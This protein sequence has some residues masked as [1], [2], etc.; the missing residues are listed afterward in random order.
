MKLTDKQ[1]DWQKRC[2]SHLKSKIEYSINLLRKAEKLALAYDGEDG[3]YLAFSGGKDSQVLYHIAELAGVKFKAHMNFTSVDPPQVVRFVRK[4]Y[5]EVV[6]H[7]P[8]RSIYAAAVDRMILPTMRIRWCC[9]EFKETAGAGK[10]TLI[11]IRKQESSRR[12]KRNEVEI[13][14]RKFSGTLEGL[15][16]YREKKVAKTHDKHEQI[17]IVN[18][19]GERTLGCINSKE[20]LLISPLLSW[21]DADV[22]TFLND[23]VMV[24][25]CE[26]YDMGFSRVG[27]VLCPMSSRKVKAK[28]AQLYPEAKHRWIEAIKEIRRRGGGTTSIPMRLNKL[29][30]NSQTSKIKKKGGVK[31]FKDG[32]LWWNMPADPLQGRMQKGSKMHKQQSPPQCPSNALHLPSMDQQPR[33]LGF[34]TALLQVA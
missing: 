20:S 7:A 17:S 28:M 12:A 30:E 27:C 5:P 10:V 16:T 4:Q 6:T 24:P 1:K 23:V 34:Q 18:A 15:D 9:A 11:G 21:T 2:P 13:N 32:Y 26:L 8:K 33:Q 29:T 3:Y 19:K 22:W 31:T 14:S 25:H